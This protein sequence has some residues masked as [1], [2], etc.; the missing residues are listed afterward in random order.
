MPYSTKLQKK[1]PLSDKTSVIWAFLHL[2]L[3]E[4]KICD[5]ISYST[6]LQ[7]NHLLSDKTSKFFLL[8]DKIA[9]LYRKMEVHDQ[10]TDDKQYL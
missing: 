9:Y 5:G 10:E 3:T 8:S 4:K 2:L 6:K 7:K 1:R